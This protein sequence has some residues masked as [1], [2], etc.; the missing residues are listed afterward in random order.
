[1]YFKKLINKKKKINTTSVFAGNSLSARYILVILSVTAI[2]LIAIYYKSVLI[3]CQQVYHID[4]FEFSTVSSEDIST[5]LFEENESGE[6]KFQENAITQILIQPTKPIDVALPN[7]ENKTYKLLVTELKDIQQ[8]K[9][10]EERIEVTD[11]KNE[12]EVNTEGSE[13][14]S[15]LS[16]YSHNTNYNNP[17]T[18]PMLQ[19]DYKKI[20]EDI[21]LHHDLLPIELTSNDKV[22]F[23]GDS[24]MQGIAPYVKKMLFKQYKIESLD[25]SKQST[26]LA[27][28]NA[29]N[30]PKTINDN[31]IADP[32]I[33][34]L[35]VFLGA[36]DPWDF[37]VKGYSKYAKFKSELWEEQYRLR[38]VSILNSAI[39]HN[40]QVLWLAAPCMRKPKL[41]DGMIYLN[42]LYKSELEKFQQYFLTT[43]ELLGC[44]Y[45]K[46]SNFIETDKA[47]IKVRV[48]DGVHFTPTGQKILANAIME[49]IIYKESEDTRSD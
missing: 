7:A 22:F 26:G 19:D 36:N 13:I 44:T 41:N 42:N 11:Q 1:M 35:V 30:W 49:K 39:E 18:Q 33:K 16:T 21:K 24:L 46:F 27:Y 12:Q 15:N 32:S 4:L 28:P 43:N 14:D 6:Q 37:P 8:N 3:Y 5:N 47:K 29:F 38:I 23:A 25:L 17:E 45:E 10:I 20:Q 40:V 31:L 2:A 48:D 9:K 34:L